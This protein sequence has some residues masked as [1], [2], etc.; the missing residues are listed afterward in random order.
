MA[1]GEILL[2]TNVLSELVRPRPDPRVVAF[3]AA[4]ASPLISAV[5]LHEI[6]FGA[7]RA[8]T[9]K[10]RAEL[11][12][13]LRDLEATFARRIVS[14]DADVAILAGQLRSTAAAKGAAAD[15]L[16]AMIAACAAKHDAGIAT[17]NT[18]DFAAFDLHLIN[19][20]EA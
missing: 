7:E 5:T 1:R 10:R 9:P 8:T 16:D 12:D 2:D 20:W 14:I 4:V 6:A 18:R 15:P 19:P 11:L 13:W 3:V 17:R